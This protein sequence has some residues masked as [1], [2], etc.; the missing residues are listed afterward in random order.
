MI[1]QDAP[2]VAEPQAPAQ[3]AQP[4]WAGLAV[5][6]FAFLLPLVWTNRVFS[7]FVVPKAALALAL[8]GPGLIL[9]ALLARRRDPAAC[10]GALFLVF[11]GLATL[12]ADAPMMSLLGDYFSLNGLLMVVIVVA[13]WALGRAAA[14]R[15]A[16]IE[17]A[18]LATAAVN[19]AVGWLQVSTSLS[20]EGLAPYQGRAQGLM[21]NPAFFA[22]LLSG[23]LW[24]ALERERRAARPLL[25]LLLVA[26]LFGAIELSA[27][28][29]AFV[30]AV[31][32]VLA[33]AAWHL[34]ARRWRRAAAVVAVA[35]VGFGVAQLP[36]YATTS[37]A[38]RV[39]SDAGGFSTRAQLWEDGIEGWAEKPLLGYGPGRS[40]AATTPRRSLEIARYEGPDTLYSDVHNVF[41]EVLV[42][43]GALGF[44]AFACWLVLSARRAR[45]ALAGFA[46]VA[47]IS[48]LVEPQFIGLV[49]VMA[50]A[51]GAAVVARP[52]SR[53]VDLRLGG[54]RVLRTLAIALALTGLIAGGLLLRGDSHYRRAVVDHSISDLT[55]AEATMPPWPQLPGVHAQLL[56]ER[57]VRTSDQRAARRALAYEREAQRRDPADPRWWSAAGAIEERFGSA[58]RANSAYHH[59]LELS[60]WSFQA[61][62]GL[63]RVAVRDGHHRAAVGYRA[64]LCRLGPAFC[65]P[66]SS[67]RGPASSGS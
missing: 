61:L 28:R 1:T 46:A 58:A 33:F 45:G 56:F 9:L 15:A 65:P 62:G 25:P 64:T 42:T 40:I 18:I 59:A 3:R 34:R 10:A 36:S 63:Y 23:A 53:S 8:I 57:A 39:Q 52:D 54:S 37:G 51:L 7:W 41:V 66:R 30:V 6:A 55:V 12:F 29:V 50:L 26:F 17:V 49:P 60:P 32:V 48:L 21:A 22:A 24:I 20:I 43:T 14:D 2:A 35:I 67:L 5:A 4:D 16:W 38:T 44:L 13:A 27:S 31:V 11:A 47:G 19:A